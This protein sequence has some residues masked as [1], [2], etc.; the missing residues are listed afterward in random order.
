M[1]L[2]GAD[3]IQ[4]VCRVA[5]QPGDTRR[6]SS[7]RAREAAALYVRL[8]I[9][10]LGAAGETV[11]PPES[12]RNPPHGRHAGPGSCSVHD[13]EEPAGDDKPRRV[14]GDRQEAPQKKKALPRDGEAHNTRSDR[15]TLA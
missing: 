11:T 1:P 13:T 10:R 9:D 6:L 14:T 3:C 12:R 15:I 8:E 2:T 7:T 5:H 4:I